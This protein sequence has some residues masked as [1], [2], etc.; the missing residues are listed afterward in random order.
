VE[1]DTVIAILNGKLFAVVVSVFLNV[2]PDEISFGPA[3][4]QE[5]KNQYN[6]FH[7][8]SKYISKSYFYMTSASSLVSLK[9]IQLGIHKPYGNIYFAEYGK[10]IILL[11]FIRF[12]IGY[13]MVF[14]CSHNYRFKSIVT[15]MRNI[16]GY[17]HLAISLT[18]N[19]LELFV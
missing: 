12:E 4:Q 13:F 16:I 15:N 18:V 9:R 19:T 11:I 17:E 5:K 14:F 2:N 7:F 6:V 1:T 8:Q 3:Q 10:H